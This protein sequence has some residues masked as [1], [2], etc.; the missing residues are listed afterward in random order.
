M[1]HLH[2]SLRFAR[3]ST[4]ITLGVITSLLSILTQTYPAV[5]SG[6][7]AA[8]SNVGSSVPVFGNASHSSKSFASATGPV[9]DNNVAWAGYHTAVGQYTAATMSWRVPTARPVA[10][11]NGSMSSIWPGIGVGSAQDPLIQAGTHADVICPGGPCTTPFYYFWWQV[12]PFNNE[13]KVPQVPVE[14]G[15]DVRVTVKYSTDKKRAQITLANVSK[16]TGTFIEFDLPASASAGV[17]T[18]AQWIVERPQLCF[19]EGCSWAKLTN[20]GSIAIT[21]ASAFTGR[22][23]AGGSGTW[24]TVRNV[25]AFRDRSFSCDGKVLLSE[26]RALSAEDAFSVDWK[27]SGDWEAC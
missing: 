20:F 17:A 22:A 18:Q 11:G 2:S 16:N 7:T 4:F 24:K 27:A 12:Y 21:A 10:E 19:P 5:A 8:H 15:D 14:A 26:P 13:Q 6:S 25:A 23:N 3:L 9:D 1:S